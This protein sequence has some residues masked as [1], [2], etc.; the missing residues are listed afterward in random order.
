LWGN[1][2]L[3]MDHQSLK[4]LFTQRDLNARQRRWSE[5]MSEYDFG[6]SYIKGKKNVVADALS[7][8][9]RVFSLVP[10][11]V[12]LRERVLTQLQEDSWYLK[13]TSNLQSGRQLDPKYERY[14]LEVEG[15]FRY[16]GRMYI[17]ENG[18]IRSIILKEAHRS[19]YCVH[20][21]VKKMYTDM[22]KI[23]FWVGMKRDVVHFVTKFLECKQVKPDHHHPPGLLQQHD[24]P[25]SKWEVISMD[26]VVGLPLTSHRHNAILVIVDK[27]TKSAYFI[28]IR[29]NYDVTDVA[30]VF[31][32]EVI[33][34]HGI[35][36]NIILDRD[37]IFTSRI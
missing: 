4:H 21:G 33:C 25:M 31:V 36:K 12:N 28:L 1:F 17:L 8:R 13:F 7:R 2:E 22:R 9:P 30:C 35:P 18:D 37:S 24:V 23:F 14:C 11:K 32:S 15:L 16:R 19:L 29:D 20:P 10:L 26:F 3:K 6:I 5:F 27:L 34:L